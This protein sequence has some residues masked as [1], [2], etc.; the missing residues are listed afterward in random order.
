M[1]I[2]KIKVENFRLLKNFNLDLEQE[3]SLVIG[4]TT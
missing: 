2:I 4:K 1:K 3:L